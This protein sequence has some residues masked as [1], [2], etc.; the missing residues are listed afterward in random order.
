MG[1]RPLDPYTRERLT[2]RERRRLRRVLRL[3]P[4]ES[5]PLARQIDGRTYRGTVT[6]PWAVGLA[7]HLGGFVC[8]QLS[9]Q[10]GFRVDF[11]TAILRIEQRSTLIWW[12][13]PGEVFAAPW[14]ADWE[15]SSF[16]P[17]SRPHPPILALPCTERYPMD[18]AYRVSAGIL[19]GRS[20]TLFL[21]G[22]DKIRDDVLVMS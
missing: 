20:G 19:A 2:L 17:S 4:D 3:R 18:V 9:H 12:G 7:I 15:G 6:P 13:L 16:L 22:R 21:W 8:R 10:E 5:E 14:E 11:K 1:G